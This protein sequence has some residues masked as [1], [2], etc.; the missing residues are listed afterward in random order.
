[1][2]ANAQVI[3][4]SVQNAGPVNGT[5]PLNVNG[6]ISRI[7]YVCRQSYPPGTVID[8]GPVNVTGFPPYDTITDPPLGL[9]THLLAVNDVFQPAKPVAASFPNGPPVG[10]GEVE[11]YVYW[12]Y[13]TK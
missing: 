11:I 12:D 2:S 4:L 7:D 5:T 13:P 8:V 10:G 1:M 9:T 3:H 6:L